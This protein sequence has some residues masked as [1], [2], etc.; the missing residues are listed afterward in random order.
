VTT[1]EADG[2]RLEVPWQSGSGA[3]YMDLAA[4]PGRLQE[5]AAAR[6]NL[7]LTTFLAAIN[8]DD[9][10]F[11]TARCSAGPVEPRPGTGTPSQYASTVALLFAAQANNLEPRHVDGLARQLAELLRRDAEADALEAEL[12]VRPCRFTTVNRDGFHLA[13]SLRAAGA[14]PA[15]AALRWG[16]G[17]VRIQQALMFLSRVIRGHLRANPAAG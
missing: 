4:E 17:L 1:G 2:E 3:G 5:I 15:Q 7:A 13:I 10:V 11:R 14:D 12:A 6:G 9:S 16:L 8:S